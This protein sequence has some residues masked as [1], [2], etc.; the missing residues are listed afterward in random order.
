MILEHLAINSGHNC[1]K[2]LVPARVAKKQHSAKPNFSLRMI[3]E[4]I[5]DIQKYIFLFCG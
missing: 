2:M 1:T 5:G 4:S 3:W